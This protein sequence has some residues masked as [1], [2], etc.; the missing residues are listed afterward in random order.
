M[1]LFWISFFCIGFFIATLAYLVAR[2]LALMAIVDTIWTAGLGLTA[3]IYHAVA[4]LD[5][6]RS[7][8]VLLVAL[9]W[10]FRL[11]FHLFKDRVFAGHEDPRYKSLAEHWGDKAPIHFYLLF[12]IQIVFIALFLIPVSVAMASPVPFGLWTDFLALGIA[13]LAMTGETIADR[14]LAVFRANPDNKGGVCQSGLWRYSRH[15][16]YFFEWLHWFAY[17]FLALGSPSVWLACLGPVVMYVFLRFL[18]GVPYAERSSLKSRGDAYRRYQ[19]TTHAFF[20]WTP[21]KPSA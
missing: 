18:T 5:S 3:L 13:A 16:N 21:R 19:A 10:S 2:R 1:L 9:L 7:W 12:L 14:Q 17:L 4:G 20:P 15:P 11:S 8:L 6:V